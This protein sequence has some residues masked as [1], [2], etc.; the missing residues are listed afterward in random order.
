MNLIVVA[1]FF[2]ATCTAIFQY[3][4]NTESQK[5]GLLGLT[6]TYFRIEEPMVKE[7]YTYIVLCGFVKLINYQICEINYN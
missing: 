5:N 6:S 2:E 4:L 1:K 7:Y 3:L